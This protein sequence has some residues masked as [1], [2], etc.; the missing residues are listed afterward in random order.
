MADLLP[1]AGAK[2]YIGD[3]TDAQADDFVAGDF[4]AVTWV[5]IDGWQN[6]GSLGDTSEIISKN[7]INR[8]RTVKQKGTRDAGDMENVFEHISGD[9]GM[10]NVVTAEGTKD[11]YAFRIVFDDSEGT[12]GTTLYFV[13]LVTTIQF[14]GGEANDTM[15]RNVTLAINSNIVEVAAS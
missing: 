13:A 14:D 4:S 5:E 10:A 8:G 7:L 3:Q 9:T 11:N 12:A 1:V 6:C 15:T 2:I